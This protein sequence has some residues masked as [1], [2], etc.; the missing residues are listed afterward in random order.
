MDIERLKELIDY[1]EHL[2]ALND[3][4][5][6]EQVIADNSVQNWISGVVTALGEIIANKEQ[7]D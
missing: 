6:A 3:D 5:L 4:H 1:G 7:E 2:E